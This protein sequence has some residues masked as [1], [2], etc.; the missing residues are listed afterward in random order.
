[1]KASIYKPECDFNWFLEKK[2]AGSN[3]VVDSVKKESN[4]PRENPHH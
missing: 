3:S 2:S 4:N 1:M